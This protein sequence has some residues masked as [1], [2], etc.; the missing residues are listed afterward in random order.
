MMDCV[1][2][3][4]NTIMLISAPKVCECLAN[5]VHD[6]MVRIDNAMDCVLPWQDNSVDKC[7]GGM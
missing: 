7:I 6:M 1:C 2:H 4:G 5:E 3:Y